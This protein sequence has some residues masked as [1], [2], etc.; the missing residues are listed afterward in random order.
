MKKNSLHKWARIIHRDLGYF[1]FALLIVYCISGV[2][3]N[4]RHNWNGYYKTLSAKEIKVAHPILKDSIDK[5]FA[6]NFLD[7]YGYKD[8]FNRFMCRGNRSIRDATR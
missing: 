1:I 2:V 7:K 5:T 8:E 4:H 3:L 6:I